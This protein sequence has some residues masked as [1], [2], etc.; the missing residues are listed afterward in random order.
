MG[1]G[2]FIT[3]CCLAVVLVGLASVI[4][5]YYKEIG[6]MIRGNCEAKC[7][8]RKEKKKSRGKLY[9]KDDSLLFEQ[10]ENDLVEFNT[11]QKFIKFGWN[12]DSFLGKEA[13]QHKNYLTEA[14]SAI[15]PKTLWVTQECAIL[16]KVV[17]EKLDA[18][19]KVFKV[20]ITTLKD[21]E[22]IQEMETCI[23]KKTVFTAILDKFYKIQKS[24]DG[25]KFMLYATKK[26]K[27]KFGELEILENTDFKKD[28]FSKTS[29]KY[30][31]IF[32]AE[33]LKQ[34]DQ[35]QKDTQGESIL[36]YLSGNKIDFNSLDENDQKDVLEYLTIH[37]NLGASLKDTT[38][39]N[40]CQK[41]LEKFQ[42][43]TTNLQIA[44]T[45]KDG[46]IVCN[47]GEC[48]KV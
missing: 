16:N 39:A 31:V 6:C 33:T 22:F 27:I 37:L 45:R 32:L 26:E 10:N 15:D 14:I 41:A 46:K 2:C 11:K 1:K 20:N 23:Q 18:G 13:H 9:L 24:T 25:K 3:A 17:L 5:V 12:K 8:E 42:E 30:D 21:T 4:A 28:L 43:Y 44:C 38:D 34:I 47:T 19:K 35:N 48:N 7:D 40:F 29:D 36:V